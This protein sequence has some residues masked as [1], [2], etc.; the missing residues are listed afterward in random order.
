[1]GNYTLIGGDQKQYGSVSAEDMR[2]WIAE[3]RLSA[4]TL[5][6]AEGEETFRPLGQFPEFAAALGALGQA[7]LPGPIQA[8]SS[9]DHAAAA[10]QVKGPAI[11]LIITAGLG[12]AYYAFS[13]IFTLI[14]GG[15]IFNQQMPANVP[16]EWQS[17]IQSLYH[18]QGPMTGVI[19]LAIAALN[20]FVLFG[21]IKML[22]LQNH[23]IAV[24]A[25]VVAMLPCQCCC[26]LGLPFGIW[27]LV[28]LNKPEV[29][30][31]FT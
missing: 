23:T 2:K 22:R 14:T 8:V 27:A 31:Q 17:F 3:G 19:N 25:A 4:Q 12:A 5:V 16:P 29:K 26:V 24:I 18:M 7:A 13:G 6:K 21:A 9:A 30:S 15:M 10:Q 11:A 20:G 28:A 1:M